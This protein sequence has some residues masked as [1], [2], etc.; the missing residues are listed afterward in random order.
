[1]CG[2]GF[3]LSESTIQS[4][5]ESFDTPCIFTALIA[6]AST[7]KSGAMSFIKTAVSTIERWLGIQDNNSQLSQTPTVES[8]LDLLSRLRTIIGLL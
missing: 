2:I 8:L 5:P 6:F 3:Y 4:F 7:G 1:M